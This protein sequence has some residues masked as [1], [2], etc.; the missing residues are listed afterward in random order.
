MNHKINVSV[1][2]MGFS[3]QESYEFLFPRLSSGVSG[4]K[5]LSLQL[6]CFPSFSP[7]ITYYY[8][9]AYSKRKPFQELLILGMKLELGCSTL[10]A[11]AVW[12]RLK[13]VG[14]EARLHEGQGWV[15]LV[16]KSVLA[17]LHFAE[18][19]MCLRDGS[20]PRSSTESSW[21]WA[22]GFGLSP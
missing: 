4:G 3:V 14:T 19:A 11:L 8:T 7:S 9:P 16:L 21:S 18:F 6:H 10:P 15:L 12:R 5:Q 1:M 20:R 13:K 2:S 22:F 17:R